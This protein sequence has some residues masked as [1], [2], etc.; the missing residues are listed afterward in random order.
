MEFRTGVRLGVFW[1]NI[2]D[3][4]FIILIILF[5]INDDGFP[6]SALGWF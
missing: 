5:I 3:D 1:S 6:L 4:L 2:R